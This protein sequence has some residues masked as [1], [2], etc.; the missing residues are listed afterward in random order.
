MQ[1]RTILIA[2]AALFVSNCT[3]IPAIESPVDPPPSTRDEV[4]AF[5]QLVNQHRRKVGCKELTWIG[6]VASIAQQHSEDMINH[7]FFSHV[8]HKG[9]DPFERLRR[10]GIRYTMAAENIAAGQ[11]TAA[12]VLESWLTSKGHRRN[13]ED[14]QLLQHGVGLANNR[15]THMFVRLSQ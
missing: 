11:R 6:A 3:M 9:Q 13:I 1:K 15:W 7:N 14:C 5:A 2:A 10:A 12:D 8:N 4:R